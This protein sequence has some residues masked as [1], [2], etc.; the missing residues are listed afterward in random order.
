MPEKKCLLY[1]VT[2]FSLILCYHSRSPIKHR[3]CLL[4]YVNT[5]RKINNK[6]VITNSWLNIT[7]MLDQ[8]QYQYH[9]APQPQVPV[10]LHV[11]PKRK[12]GSLLRP[13]MGR[14]AQGGCGGASHLWH[15]VRPVL[16]PTCC[17]CAIGFLC[18]RRFL[19][20]NEAPSF[21][22]PSA[23]DPRQLFILPVPKLSLQARL[24]IDH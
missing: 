24:N 17:H 22:A 12:A 9:E 1:S 2:L 18:V 19:C 10:T 23:S 13:G 20:L 16:A 11:R 5:L 15:H 7:R 3:S 21:V 14:A 8:S 6:C 4:I